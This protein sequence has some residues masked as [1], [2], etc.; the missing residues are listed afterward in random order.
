MFTLQILFIVI[1]KVH[2]LLSTRYY[3]D[4]GMQFEGNG[5]LGNGFDWV[6]AF[7]YLDS[8]LAIAISGDVIWLKGGNFTYYP[9]SPSDRTDCFAAKEGIEIYGGFDGTENGFNGRSS[10]IDTRPKSIISGDIGILND[11]SDNCYHVLQYKRRLKLDN[12]IIEGGN[13]NYNGNDLDYTLH[14]YGGALITENVAYTTDLYLKDVTISN[15]VALNGGAL[16]FSSNDINNVNVLI[17][18]SF[19]TNNHA[20]KGQFTGGYA[21]AI[22][23]VKYRLPLFTLLLYLEMTDL[24]LFYF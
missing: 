20:L 11:I 9:Q 4:G 19:F 1:C 18:D 22:Y 12:V 24:N 3:V 14:K 10:N 21:G 15:N 6:T 17:E 23:I 7:K 16:F 8:A 13:A 2:I 5:E